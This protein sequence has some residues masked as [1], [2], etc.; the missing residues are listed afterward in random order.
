MQ[1]ILL[2]RTLR[3]LKANAFRYLT[4]FLLIVLAL[5]MVI[6]T[7]ASAESVIKTVNQKSIANHLED[8]SF[9]LFSPLTKEQLKEIKEMGVTLEPCFYID[10]PMTDDSV[11]RLMKTRQNINLLELKKGRLAK[12]ENEVVIERIYA[13]AHSLVPGDTMS[14]AQN[15]YVVTGIVTSPDY[16]HCLRSI[17]DMSSDGKLFGT[18]FV[19]SAAYDKLT[20]GDK[21]IGSQEYRYSYRL[22]KGAADDDLKDY[23]QNIKINSVGAFPV[24]IQNLTDFLKAADNPRIKAANDDVAISVNIGLMAGAVVL[25]LLTYVISVFVVHSID[26]ESAMIGALYALGVKR[27][28]LMLHYTMLPVVLCLSGGILGTALGYSHG[29]ITLMTGSTLSYYSIPAIETFYSPYLLIYGLILPPLIAFIVNGLIIKGRLARTA[30]S[31]LRKEQP[32][33]K[34]NQITLKRLGFLR[35]FQVRQFLREKRSCLAVLA[36]IFVSLLILMLGL[37]C[38]ALCHNIQVQNAQ[39]TKYT[40]MYRYKYPSK[41][42]PDGGHAAYIKGLKKEALGYKMEVSLIGIEKGNPFFPSIKSKKQNEIS[43]SNS[44]AEKYGL[45]VGDKTFFSDEINEKEYGFVVKEIVP[46][47]VGLNCFMDVGSMRALFNQE[48]DYYNV[49]YADTALDVDSGSLYSISTK[50]DVKKSSEIFMEIMMPMMSMMTG[51][52]AFIFLIVLYQMMKV[53]TD[54]SA[55]S[56]SLMKIFGYR[57]REIRKLYLDGNFLL[58]ALGTLVMLPLAKQLIDMVYP[59][60]IANVACG[61]NLS[62]PLVLYAAV[63]CGTLLGYLLI[64]MVLMRRLKKVTPAEV[65]KN[66][67]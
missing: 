10:V 64:R 57:N 21:T 18:A 2:R 35:T 62:W 9:G 54:R 12:A 24:E 7:V 52:A 26:R 31:L 5:F 29:G 3:D 60:F 25:I 38:Y 47:S 61:I 30:L 50:D 13:K 36:G 23:L 45:S 67:E 48:K 55:S 20:S 59:L 46:Y 44:V 37:N 17:A 1:K 11:L 42:V 66:R 34:V 6:S 39:D 27:K 63:Y 51:A 4:L 8:G 65:L 16:D 33:K 40:F 19:T 43:I 53:M 41:T 58:V 56:I 49:V 22:G 28:Q 14:I 15:K 32:E